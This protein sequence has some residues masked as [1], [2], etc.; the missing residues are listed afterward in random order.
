MFSNPLAPLR[1]LTTKK[2]QDDQLAELLSITDGKVTRIFDAIGSNEGFAKEVLKKVDAKPK[3][4]STTN[5]GTP[6]TAAE[7]GGAT[8]YP[9]QLGPIGRADATDLNKDLSSYIPLIYNLVE[10]GKIVPAEYEVIGSTGFES[11]PEAW[12]YQG[13]GKAGNKKVLVK[14]QEP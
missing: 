11:V 1:Q 5:D 7:F 9:V 4:F 6:M 10:S 8:P 14:L 3:Y 12:K 13:S 2:S